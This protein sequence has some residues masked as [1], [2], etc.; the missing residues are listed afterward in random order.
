[1]SERKL[2]VRD[3]I[4]I[5]LSGY[6]RFAEEF[7]CPEEMAQAGI[8]AAIGKSRAHTT[9]ELNRME[10]VHMVTERLAHVK[11][12]RSKRKTYNLTQ[13]ALARE[14]EI[15]DSIR[16]L[17]I[18]ILNSGTEMMNGL[19]AAEM[20]MEELTI[21]RAMAFGIVLNSDGIID[22]DEEREKQKPASSSV[23]SQQGTDGLENRTFD[24]IMLQANILSK[25]GLQNDALAILEKTMK[26]E[27]SNTEQA[28]VSYTRANIL[29]KQGNCPSA[30]KSIDMALARAQE[31]GEKLITAR[32]QMEKVMI[33]SAS[34]DDS[35]FLELMD[36][37]EETFRQENSQLDILRCGVNQGI[38]LRRMGNFQEAIS[39]L[40]DS[41]EHAERLGQDRLRAYALVNLTDILNEQGE[42]RRSMELAASAGDIF[43]VLD[44]PL[45]L[46]ASLFNL[47]DAQAGLG[48]K[49]D[50]IK[51]L[52][53]AISIL[54]RDGISRPGWLERYATILRE[55]DEPDRAVE[56]LKKI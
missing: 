2:T 47:G 1:M 54:E 28:R 8:S 3:R 16:I 43:Q 11:N 56:I 15:V 32:C 37:A 10:D 19:Q 22:I 40:E 52:D 39:V 17:N 9:L 13:D 23:H 27:L 30:L 38:I 55:L 5:H 20:L 24:A 34:G 45:M 21:S 33:L 12:A 46:A 41:V 6:T 35:L 50:A 36:S 48:K 31:S 53:R 18:E 25:K 51:N 44:E 7:E 14:V 49:D 4:I 42:Y 26:N 29:R